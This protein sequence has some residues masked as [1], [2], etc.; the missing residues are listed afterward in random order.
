MIQIPRART[1]TLGDANVLACPLCDCDYT[2]HGVVEVFHRPQ[3]DARYQ[4]ITTDGRRAVFSSGA[5]TS[6]C[7]SSRRDGL[8]LRF[9]CEGCHGAFSLEISQHK[10][11]TILET[12]QES[13]SAFE[14]DLPA[15]TWSKHVGEFPSDSTP[16]DLTAQEEEIL[17]AYRKRAVDDARR[18]TD[19]ILG[20]TSGEARVMQSI[21]SERA[22]QLDR[23]PVGPG[24]EREADDRTPDEFALYVLTYATKL[25][26]VAGSTRDPVEQM[27]GF[28]KV[29]ALCHAAMERHGAPKRE[30]R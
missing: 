25:A 14:G 5:A 24:H 21:R 17:A 3:E 10:G 18:R 27:A 11:Q 23:W 12:E 4:Q 9:W 22:Y 13:A 28:R 15:E 29:A 2:H 26:T 30:G 7:P 16:E 20:L 6:P 1:T 8:R 19:G